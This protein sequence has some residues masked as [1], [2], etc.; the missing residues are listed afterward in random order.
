M[1]RFFF[2]ILALFL[3]FNI[4]LAGIA[5]YGWDLFTRAGPLTAER[6]LILKKGSG[7]RAIAGQLKEEGIIHNDLAFI[8]G[9]RIREQAKKL[10][11]GE[12]LFP[13]G[14]SAEQVM[15]LL[16]S[17]K[18]VP[19]FLTIPEGLQIR[20][21]IALI[22]GETLLEGELTLN[23]EEGSVLP[24]TYHFTRGETKNAVALRMKAALTETL[25]E[26]WKTRKPDP[27]VKTKEDLLI[28]AS[29]VE[30]ETGKASERGRVAGVFLNRLKRKMRLQSDPTVVYGVTQGKAELGRP[31]SKKDLAAINDYN[32]YVISALP[33]GPI[34]NPGR[35]SLKA[36]LN[37]VRSKDLYF[38][39][40]GTGGH[41]FA[42]TL[43]EHNRNVR[44]WR[45]IEKQRKKQAK[46]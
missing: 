14:V 11:A 19:H 39:A 36:V 22:N 13:A 31:I 30:K 45:K 44:K 10:K 16:V 4:A 6:T 43:D 42:R 18:T 1:K 8:F 7:L 17:G 46:P 29:I 24:E 32:T 41:L 9:V 37:P 34:C 3:L 38:V 33:A 12:F 25:E 15:A 5:A 26:L 40:D 23:L 21:V 28:L 27:L 2:F 35:D 20:D